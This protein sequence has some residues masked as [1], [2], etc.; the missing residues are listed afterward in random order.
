ML[1]METSVELQFLDAC[2]IFIA[3]FGAG[4][5]AGVYAY[6]SIGSRRVWE[7]NCKDCVAMERS[8]INRK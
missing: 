8:N 4:F 5:V 2:V 6:I 1:F 7:R 3:L